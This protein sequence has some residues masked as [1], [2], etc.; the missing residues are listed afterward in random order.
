MGHIEPSR[1]VPQHNAPAPAAQTAAIPRT[2]SLGA[3]RRQ[4]LFPDHASG[5]YLRHFEGCHLPNKIRS[6][7]HLSSE[8][9]GSSLEK[10]RLP[11]RDLVWMHS[12]LCASSASVVSPLRAAKATFALKDGVCFRRGRL[13][14]ISPEARRY[15]L[16]SGRKSTYRSVQFSGASS[17]LAFA[18]RHARSRRLIGGQRI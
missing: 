17:D 6:A 5:E 7:C 9:R 16:L 10:L 18:D 8:K 4:I 15:S 3:A 13:V 2:S 1:S 11:G 14:I 12:K